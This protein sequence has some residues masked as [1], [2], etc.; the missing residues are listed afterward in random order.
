MYGTIPKSSGLSSSSA[1][2]VCAALAT[3]FANKLEMTKV[4]AFF[5]LNFI[6]KTLFLF[7]FLKTQLAELCAV[8]ERYIGT[9]GGGMDQAISC[10]A[11]EG[12]VSFVKKNFFQNQ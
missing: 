12:T 9:Q 7:V 10:L 1:L 2:V 11:K 6:F 3:L 5:F 8:S 4:N